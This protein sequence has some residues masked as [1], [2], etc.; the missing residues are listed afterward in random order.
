MGLTMFDLPPFDSAPAILR[1]APDGYVRS[2]SGLILKDQRDAG[3]P[4]MFNPMIAFG[5]TALTSLSFVGRSAAVASGGAAAVISLPAGSAAGDLCILQSGSV[6]T[7]TPSAPAGFTALVATAS[8]TNNCLIAYKV[9]T[10]ADIL[11]GSVKGISGGSGTNRAVIAVFHPN[12]PFKSLLGGGAQGQGTSGDPV[13]QTISAT[14]ATPPVL[15]LG[16]GYATALIAMSGTLTTSGSVVA[17]SNSNHWLVYEFQVGSTANRTI[18][19]ND[20]GTANILQSCY[21]QLS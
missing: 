11:A 13:A 5:S 15:L 17:G 3:M 14:S 10:A 4:G 6:T 2:K 19:C 12:T 1:P 7:S 20:G 18:D 21:L 16:C 9:L 8:A